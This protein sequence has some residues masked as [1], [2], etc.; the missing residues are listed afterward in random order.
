MTSTYVLKSE[1]YYRNFKQSIKSKYTFLSYNYQL[2]AYMKYMGMAGGEYSQ[3]IEGKYP[4]LIES[5]IIDFIISL[6]ERNYSSGSQK[7]CLSALLHFYSYND[8][9]LNR[10]KLSAYLSNDDVIEETTNYDNNNND[11]NNTESNNCDSGDKPYTHEQIA[12][13]LEYSDIR[14]RVIILIMSSAGL[15]LGALPILKIG[16][17]ISIPKHNIYQIRVYANSKSNRHYTFCTPECRKAIDN[18]IEYRRSCGENITAKSPLFRREFD[19]HDIFQVANSV[20]PIT[21]E[22]IKKSINEVLYASG[23]RTPFI[24]TESKKDKILNTRR[25]IAMS[26]G[27][28]KFFDTNCTHSGMNPIYIEFCLGHSLKGDKDSYFLP[29]PDSNGVYLDILEGHDKSIGYIDAIDYLTI[30]EENRLKRKVQQLT[31]KTDKPEILEQKMN[32]LNKR[33]GLE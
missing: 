3:L 28:R 11:N 7:T 13:L 25:Q 5:D 23:L 9:I 4:K 2:K 20:K 1:D 18:Y 31:I 14:T 17:L 24:I 6:K 10:K 33:L 15:R 21:R 19:K 32:E 29:Q 22:S 27:F 8:I 12:R 30:N 26:H 16:D